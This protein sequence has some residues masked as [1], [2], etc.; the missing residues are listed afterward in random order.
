MH[1]VQGGQALGVPPYGVSCPRGRCADVMHGRCWARSAGVHGTAKRGCRTRG[2]V[3]GSCPQGVP[4]TQGLS[5]PGAATRSTPEQAVHE[6]AV[7]EQAVHEQA[8]HE[9]AVHEQAVHEQ[10]VHEQA[11]HEQQAVRGCGGASGERRGGEGRAVGWGEG[12]PQDDG[13]GADVVRAVPRGTRGGA[14]GRDAP[15]RGRERGRVDEAREGEHPRSGG[16][17]ERQRTSG[18]PTAG[19]SLRGGGTSKRRWER[20][21]GGGKPAGRWNIQT[22]VGTSQRRWEVGGAVET[23]KRGGNARMPVGSL[24]GGGNAST[25][26]GTSE[27]LAGTP[28]CQWGDGNASTAVGTSEM[29]MGTSGRAMVGVRPGAVGRS[30]GMCRPTGSGRE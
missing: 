27:M 4:G 5:M 1:G 11:V 2:G 15:A 26:V 24:R 22:A 20:P 17:S 8:V 14:P 21:N 25:A 6:Q 28:E 7:H 10:A 13:P 23:S 29:P 19:G 16:T 9:Q 30:G 3:R 18:G 12:L